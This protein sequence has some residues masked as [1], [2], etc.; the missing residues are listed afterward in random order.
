M[1][2]DTGAILS[3]P[4]WSSRT[5]RLVVFILLGVFFYVAL[6]IGSV[7]FPVLLAF[8]LAYLLF[9]LMRRIEQGLRFIPGWGVRRNLAV[10]LTLLT[11]A[12]FIIMGGFLIVPSLSYQLESFSA[13]FGDLLQENER[14]LEST[15]RQPVQIGD[16]Q[17]ILWDE[18][19][20][21]ARDEGN[22]SNPQS[23]LQDAGSA[24]L[25]P[26]LRILS[27][28]AY[29]VA[30][31]FFTLVMMVYILR[32]GD[33]FFVDLQKIVPQSYQG[34]FVWLSFELGKIWN[35][36][37]RGQL[38]LC[39]TIG[40]FTYLGA[41]LIG[42]PQPLILALIAGLLEFIPMIGPTLAGVPGVL[43]ALATSSHTIP[44]LEGILFALVTALMYFGIQLLENNYVLPRVMGY[45]LNLHP[46]VVLVAVL[47]ATQ[48]AGFLGIILAAPTTATLRLGLTY[49]YDKLF[50]R[51]L[52]AGI[53]AEAVAVMPSGS[54]L[55]ARVPPVLTE[56]K[57]VDEGNEFTEG[58]I[59]DA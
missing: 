49:I 45:S 3:S 11:V 58:E 43:F 23:L 54:V 5:K 36:Y 30:M 25:N 26:L 29:F 34:D 1:S 13:S 52:F 8:L 44:G 24:L 17:V 37:F 35:A 33:R 2:S 18:L 22:S 46:F 41:L 7:W 4:P 57:R 28:V 39:F 10:L 16:E 40:V 51:G 50:E 9:P 42:L 19:Q 12:L 53:K 6:Q 47:F 14:N 15:L 31:F 38:I 20:R 32:D 55:V 48:I 21:L 27:D 59:V 56:P